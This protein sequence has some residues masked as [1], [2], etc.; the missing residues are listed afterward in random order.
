MTDTLLRTTPVQTRSERTLAK[1][2]AATRDA[3]RL[4][5]VHK[6]RTSDIASLADVSIGTVYRYFPD[7]VDALLH[8]YPDG[9]PTVVSIQDL[10]AMGTGSV[11]MDEHDVVHQLVDL[12]GEHRGWYSIGRNGVQFAT[13][14]ELLEQHPSTLRILNNTGRT[15]R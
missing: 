4:R 8:V 14:A 5:G 13:D 9:H 2:E 12:P 11:V 10:D 7:R 3:I 15:T 1:L 6:F